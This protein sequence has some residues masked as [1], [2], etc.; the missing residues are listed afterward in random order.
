[1]TRHQY[2]ISVL[3][4]QTS[5]RGETSGGVAKCRQ[6]SRVS[7]YF[8]VSIT[9]PFPSKQNNFT[10]PSLDYSLLYLSD[11][12]HDLQKKLKD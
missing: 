1:M 12:C 6:F 4:S 10:N 8:S 9:F 3:V 5:F 7:L 2:G 11:F